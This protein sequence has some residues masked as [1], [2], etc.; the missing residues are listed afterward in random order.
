MTDLTSAIEETTTTDA[1]GRV[2]TTRPSQVTRVATSTDESGQVWTVTQ[3]IHNPTAGNDS[4]NSKDGNAG[5]F[6]NTGAVA[7]TFVVVGLAI[8]AGILAFIFFMLKRRRR[9]RLDRDVA[10]A[11]AAA[12][13]G[14]HHSRS[15]FDDDEDEK[16]AGMQHGGFY[17]ATDIH[18]QPEQSAS[19][20]HDYEDP[21]GGYDHYAANLPQQY[22]GGDRSSVATAAGMAGFGAQAAQA[23]YGQQNMYPHQEGY[24]EV[25]DHQQQYQQQQ[26]GY[27][28]ISRDSVPGQNGYYFDPRDAT[29]FNYEEDAYAYNDQNAQHQAQPQGPGHAR[30]GSEGSIAPPGTAA[31][32]GPGLKI[33]NA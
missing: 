7:G 25:T 9:Q 1:S 30:S 2:V 31:S 15:N 23:S 12:A 26:Q 18:G 32:S 10:A 8:T 21:S 27:N 20:Y 28:A 24:E 4:S 13:A 19:G 14:A 29:Q 3:V 11:A 22:N 6:D 5:F 17:A 33:T 16:A